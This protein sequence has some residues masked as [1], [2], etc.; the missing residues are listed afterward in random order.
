MDISV[1][2]IIAILLAS[3]PGISE[4]VCL[5]LVSLSDLDRHLDS[6]TS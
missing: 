2:D 3:T 1:K 4:I 5:K 6:V